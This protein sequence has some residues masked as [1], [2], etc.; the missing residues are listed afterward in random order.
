MKK[1]F[2]TASYFILAFCI[3]AQNKIPTN[4]TENS[5]ISNWIIAKVSDFQEEK[6]M[7][8]GDSGGP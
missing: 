3:L 8:E 4:S 2:F 7:E 5:R 6:I 1:I